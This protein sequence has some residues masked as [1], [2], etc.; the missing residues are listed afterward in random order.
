MK[1]GDVTVRNYNLIR[2]YKGM[3][4]VTP[5]IPEQETAHPENGIAFCWSE[6]GKITSRNDMDI[7]QFRE[8]REFN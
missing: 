5:R 8:E 7:I 4:L 3:S 2:R 6:P 1:S